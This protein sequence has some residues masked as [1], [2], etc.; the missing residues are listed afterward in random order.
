MKILSSQTINNCWF[1][2]AYL[3]FLVI[4]LFPNYRIAEAPC[5]GIDA[6]W[7]IALEMAYQKGFIFGKDIIFTYGPLGRLT[8]RVAIGTSHF[9]LFLFDLFCFANI[10]FLLY[11]FLPKPLKVH[12][13]VLHFI[14]F[15]VI[16][17]L[18]GEWTGFL[19][20]FTSIFSGILFLKKQRE[21]LL[22]H[23]IVLGIINFYIK[24]NYGIIALTF[25]VILVFYA[26]FTKRLSLQ[27]LLGYLG[28]SFAFLVL[29]AFLLKVDLLA[30]FESSIYLIRGYNESQS[31]FPDNKMRAVLSSYCIFIVFV[32]ACFYFVFQRLK[33]KDFSIQTFDT[34]FVLGCVWI[35]SFVLIKYAFV[36][37]D[38]GHLS[39]FVKNAFFPF[40][41]LVYL[42]NDSWLKRLGWLMISLNFISYLVFYQ[43]IYGK[44]TFPVTSNIRVKSYILASYFQEIFSENKRLCK[45]TYP[46]EVLAKIGN[47]TVDIVPNEVSEIYFNKLNYNPRP[48][49]QSYQAY[50]EYLDAKNQV[51]YLSDSAP[52][53][54][55]Y[56]VESSDNKYAVSEETLT[57]LALLQKYQPLMAWNNKRLL[58]EKRSTVK[59]LKLIKTEKHFAEMSKPYGIKVL[60]EGEFL[61]IKVKLSYNFW[62]KMLNFCFQ[63]PQLTMK[64]TNEQAK[65]AVFRTVPDLL[66]KGLIISSEIENIDD[67]KSFFEKGFV[68]K[69]AVKSIQFDE[70]LRGIT[71]FEPQIEITEESYEMLP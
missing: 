5:S 70:V 26:F 15:F 39:S 9:E 35:C 42:S 1:K 66:E 67:V 19:L 17:S 37:A 4:L 6:S 33:K 40:L 53:Y 57:F 59:P 34:L 10:G 46:K 20:F 25:V 61:L 22:I 54:V 27:K 32:G 3:L 64:I 28:V 16:S 11:S 58:L 48:I 56:G 52:D 30:Y 13:L 69:K 49:I 43:P 65:Q 7:R 2:S 38:D 47:K 44:I 8:Q 36:R 23:A 14:F 41:L 21:S 62:G 45:I 24:I 18:V 68:E 50:N 63:P 12:Q 51:K 29:L 71:G 55:I 31:V 60:S